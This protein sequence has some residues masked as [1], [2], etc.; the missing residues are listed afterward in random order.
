[1]SRRWRI[2]RRRWSWARP[3]SSC[4]CGSRVQFSAGGGAHGDCRVDAEFLRL[5]EDFGGDVAG[6]VLARFRWSC[7]REIAAVG[8]LRIVPPQ[9]RMPMTFPLCL[10]MADLTAARIMALRP[11]ASPP[12]VPMLM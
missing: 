4:P 3:R 7:S 2:D 5:G 8:G 1:M 6:D 10:R 9:G 12:P 11:G